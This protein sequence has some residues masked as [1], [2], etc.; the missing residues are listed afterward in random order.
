[1]AVSRAEKQFLLGAAQHLGL[2]DTTHQEIDSMST[3]ERPS[4]DMV[5]GTILHTIV[6][7]GYEP[8]EFAAALGL[9]A[10][11]DPT[12]FASRVAALNPG[13]SASQVREADPTMP[14]ARMPEEMPALRDQLRNACA[15][16]VKR[17][18]ERIKGSDYTTQVGYAIMPSGA[19][20]VVAVVSRVA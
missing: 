13:E 4:K 6:E 15:P 19:F 5:L 2:P 3:T 10:N 9:P 18:K 17:A 20:F 12:S 11:T 14:V 1:M 7:A 16:A 8:G